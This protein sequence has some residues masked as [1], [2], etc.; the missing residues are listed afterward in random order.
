MA[1]CLP[2]IF[3]GVRG[4]GVAGGSRP[5]QGGPRSADG[6]SQGGR[7]G[8][9]RTDNASTYTRRLLVPGIRPLVPAEGV[10]SA[11]HSRSRA[12]ETRPAPCR[13]PVRTLPRP[14]RVPKGPPNSRFTYTVPSY[15]S[16]FRPHAS[17]PPD[18]QSRQSRASPCRHLP[19]HVR[20]ATTPRPLLP[21]CLA[22]PPPI[23]PPWPDLLLSSALREDTGGDLGIVFLFLLHGKT[24]KALVGLNMPH[25]ALDLSRGAALLPAQLARQP[26]AVPC[27]NQ[28]VL[29]D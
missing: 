23:W 14:C 18:M 3:A 7:E 5:S 15:L 22:G 17:P 4:S 10:A 1:P 27:S 21:G 25:I 28:S 2:P 26:S 6:P 16:I 24:G 12:L 29:G 11:N 19:G 13:A 20:C 9:R 8:D